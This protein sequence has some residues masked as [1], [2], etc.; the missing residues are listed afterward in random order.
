MNYVYLITN[1][2]N[3]KQYIG[4][5]T[6]DNLNDN[7]FGGG[8]L[9]SIK[10]KQY[11]KK[12]FKKEILEFFDDS[13]HLS[14]EEK[15][16]KKYNTIV[17]NGYNISPKGGH[18]TKN[19]VSEETKNKIRNSQ[20]GIKNENRGWKKGTKFSE[21]HKLK[22]SI[23]HKGIKQKK[24]SVEKRKIKHLGRKNTEETKLKMSLAAKGKRKNYVVWNKNK[25]FI[26]INKSII[27][28]I[29]ELQKQG[30]LQREIAEKYNFSMSSV[31]RI[32]RGFYDN[33]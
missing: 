24:E 26:K 13:D 30:F 14:I 23:S 21:E 28:E 31:S 16:I 20:K 32:L 22:L 29:K 17:P 1:L 9:L 7:Y 10:I 18:H 4:K 33:K 8:K 12:N 25:I 27:L 5:H 6:T 11:G 2:I 19:S 3:G 15:Y